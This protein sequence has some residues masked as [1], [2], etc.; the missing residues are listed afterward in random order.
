M[1]IRKSAYHPQERLNVRTLGF[2]SLPYCDV[3]VTRYVAVV[4]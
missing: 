4:R 3:E 1:E 2:I